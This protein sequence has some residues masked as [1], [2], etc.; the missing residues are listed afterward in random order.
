MVTSSPRLQVLEA[1]RERAPVATDVPYC[2]RNERGIQFMFKVTYNCLFLG[3]A[4][5]L[6]ASAGF[7]QTDM[8]LR[9]RQLPGWDSRAREG[10]CEIRVWVDNRAEVRMRGD[11][12]F[13]RT[14]EGSHSHDQGSQCS[15]ALPYNSVRDFQVHQTAGRSPINLSQEPSRMNNFTAMISIEDRQGGG[16][17]YA[18]EVTWRSEGDAV[19]APAPFFDDVRA[20]QDMVRQHFLSQNGRGSYIDFDNF[21]ERQNQNQNQGQYR[22]QGWNQGWRGRNQGRDVEIIQG[23]G[24]A[25]SWNE[26]RDLTYSCVVDKQRGEVVSGEYQLSGG[27]LP[28]NGRSRLR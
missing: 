15:Q 2:A 18:F 17:N 7:G 9:P 16:D 26:S 8:Q 22:G 1:D 20:C 13:V 25:R 6:A 12:T 27:S 3:A 10:R 14:L 11:G 19:N 24:S 28:V 23:R 4:A 21:A 5:L